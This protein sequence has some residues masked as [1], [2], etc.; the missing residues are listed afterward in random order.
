MKTFVSPPTHILRP[1]L[2]KITRRQRLQMAQHTGLRNRT[3]VKI[4]LP[5]EPWDDDGEERRVKIKSG[6]LGK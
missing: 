5:K 3:G 6:K 4:T 2:N 1:S